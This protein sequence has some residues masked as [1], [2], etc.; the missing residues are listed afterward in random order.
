M[1]EPFPLYLADRMVKHLRVALPALRKAATQ[2]IARTWEGKISNIYL[3]LHGYRS[4]WG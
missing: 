1:F 4:R 3:A 2:T